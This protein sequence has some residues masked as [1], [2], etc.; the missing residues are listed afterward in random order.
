MFAVLFSGVASFGMFELCALCCP[1]VAKRGG[2]K[3]TCSVS[4]NMCIRTFMAQGLHC[5]RRSAISGASK[6]INIW[7][8]VCLPPCCC[9]VCAACAV[10]TSATCRAGNRQ[11]HHMQMR[12]VVPRQGF[13]LHLHCLCPNR[14]RQQD[15]D[16]A[17]CAACIPLLLKS[18]CLHTV[19]HYRTTGL[20]HPRQIF[21]S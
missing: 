18:P 12:Q 7:L 5:R 16:C 1:I 4:V 17:V 11:Q 2:C 6:Q 8:V 10:S 14:P 15:R 21:A 13:R 19:K 20:L 9:K 3:G